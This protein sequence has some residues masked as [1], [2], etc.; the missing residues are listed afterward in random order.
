MGE[1]K[2]GWDGQSYSVEILISS[3]IL[4]IISYVEK[5]EG[6]SENVDRKRNSKSDSKRV[7][8]KVHENLGS[9]FKKAKTEIPKYIN[10]MTRSKPQNQIQ[11]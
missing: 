1:Y 10:Q 5:E 4:F 3:G 8:A 7:K 9:F 2:R 6:S 11:N